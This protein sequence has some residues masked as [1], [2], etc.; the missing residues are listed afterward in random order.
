MHNIIGSGRKLVGGVGGNFFF[1]VEIH[2]L[3]RCV[4]C[5]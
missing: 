4:R 2:S 3:T 5:L 1:I